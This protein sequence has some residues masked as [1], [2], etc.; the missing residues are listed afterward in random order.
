MSRFYL[1]VPQE[2]HT[3][4][5]AVQA[6]QALVTKKT[7]PSASQQ[8][9]LFSRTAV[10]GQPAQEPDTQEAGR[11]R[12][13]YTRRQL[14]V[15]QQPDLQLASFVKLRQ[16]VNAR[17]LYRRTP[18]IVAAKQGHLEC[19]Q[20]LVEAASNLFAVDREGNTSLHY[21][22]LHGHVAVVEYLMRKASDRNLGQRFVNKRNLSGFTPLHYA[23]W[24]CNEQLVQLMLQAGSDV[25]A[26]NDRVFDAWVTVPVGSTPLHLAVV[27]NHMPIAL[28]LLQHYVVQVV[29]APSDAPRP[30]DPRTMVNLYGMNPSQ[31]AAH[32]GLRQLSRILSPSLALSRVLEALEPTTRRSYGPPPLKA[33]A[34][35]AMQTVLD[36]QLDQLQQQLEVQQAAAT[37][38]AATED[39]AAKAALYN[40]QAAPDAVCDTCCCQTAADGAA[41]DICCTDTVEC[42]SPAGCCTAECA[43]GVDGP[44]SCGN[45][46]A[47]ESI[48]RTDSEE[49]YGAPVAAGTPDLPILDQAASPV[50]SDF[51]KAGV[52]DAAACCSGSS[53]AVHS[54]KR[55]SSMLRLSMEI[56]GGGGKDANWHEEQCCVCWEEEVSVSMSPCAHALCL[57]CARQLVANSGQTGATCPL[58]RSFIAVFKLLPGAGA[59]K[60]KLVFGAGI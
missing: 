29:A 9:A 12:R 34:A 21:A 57:G 43:G 17:D 13:T 23:V 1:L 22:A 15:F 55:S 50:D 37:Q 47:Q 35:G 53:G 18:L 41:A 32:R 2:V 20:T 58:C 56:A 42:S 4:R 48:R 6:Q 31:L 52:F 51:C 3:L 49:I 45:A 8:Q 14:T 24:G 26:V 44:N 16:V 10:T 59:A 28:M 11:H 27:R 46:V 36:G 39:A 33:L 30:Q 5:A 40:S 38:T 54:H 7:P 25:S 19:T 60:L